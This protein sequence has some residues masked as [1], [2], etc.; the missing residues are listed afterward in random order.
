MKTPLWNAR[1]DEL[2]GK[3]DELA[4]LGGGGDDEL[5]GEIAAAG[6]RLGRGGDDVD[7]GDIASLGEDFAEDLLGGAM[8]LAPRLQAHAAEAGERLGELEGV[9]VLRDRLEDLVHLFGVARGL[10]DGGIRR[11]VDDAE[12]DALVFLRREFAAA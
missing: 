7:A 5:D 1:A 11:G 9:L 12:D 8:A 3:L 6:Q 10:L 2:V 4:R